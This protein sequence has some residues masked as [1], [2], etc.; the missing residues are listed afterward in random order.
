MIHQAVEQKP[1]DNCVWLAEYQ[2]VL[3]LPGRAAWFG[4]SLPRDLSDVAS[5]SFIGGLM[6]CFLVYQARVVKTETKS[7]DLL[8]SV[9]LICSLL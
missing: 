2:V 8:A 9:T 5:Q 4:M 7:R 6:F 3:V 1:Y